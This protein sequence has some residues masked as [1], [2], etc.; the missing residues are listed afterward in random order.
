MSREN[1]TSQDPWEEPAEEDGYE[2]KAQF[3]RRPRSSRDAYDDPSARIRQRPQQTGDPRDTEKNRPGPYEERP[4]R[5]AGP[6]RANE[7]RQR[8]DASGQPRQ[9]TRSSGEAYESTAGP[10]R[11]RPRQTRDSRER[12]TPYDKVDERYQQRHRISRH[13]REEAYARLRQRPR[14]PISPREEVYGAYPYTQQPG[15]PLIDPD[16]EVEELDRRALRPR[17][18]TLPPQRP[19]IKRR[20]AWS[21]LLI[22]CI[23]GI[24]TIALILGVIAFVLFRTIPLN[25]GGIGKTSFTQSLPQQT[26]SI[27]SSIKQL[28]VNNHAGNISITVDPTATQ[29]TLTG[30][31]KVQAS[32]SSDAAKEFGRIAVAVK[33][34]SDPSVLTVNATVPDTSGALLTGSG[35]SVDLTIVLPS[36]VNTLPPFTL[37]ADVAAAGDIAVQNFNGVFALTD[38]TGNITVLHGLLAAGSCLQTNNGNITLGGGSILD[39]IYASQLIPCTTNTT[40]NPHPWFSIKSGKGNVDITLG[41]ESTNVILDANT[42]NGK[43]NN[44][45]GLNIQQNPDGSAT[46]H[47]P[48]I[49]GSSPTASLVLTVSTGNINLHKAA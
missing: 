16:P 18:T 46:Y 17:T 8:Y 3:R 33:P 13:S 42:N 19:V 21:T 22:G 48:L 4:K 44:D 47:G 15:R 1:D 30:V 5:H 32:N 23:G 35:D 25:F 28:Q 41:T 6:S 34:G 9:G 43:I 31:M 7:P 24:V 20:R 45:F 29:G 12:P 39:L 10:P 2:G 26:L 37:N 14:Q 36:S 38:N 49:A 11:E 27:T 40:Q